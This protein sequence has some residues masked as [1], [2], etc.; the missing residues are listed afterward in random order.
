MITAVQ[1]LEREHRAREVRLA[2][3]DAELQTLR[4]NIKRLE[5]ERHDIGLEMTSQ[6]ESIKALKV[7]D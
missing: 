1:I 2:Q 3:I 6:T 7:V 4:E 5:H